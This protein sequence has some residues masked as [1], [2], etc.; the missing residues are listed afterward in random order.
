MSSI[1]QLP[2]PAHDADATMMALA[3][4]WALE[5]APAGRLPHTRAGRRDTVCFGGDTEGGAQAPPAARP[6]PSWGSSMRC[7]RSPGQLP[8]QAQGGEAGC[9]GTGDR[10]HQPGPMQGRASPRDRWPSP[11]PDGSLPFH[12]P[13][14]RSVPGCEPPSLP[15][16]LGPPAALMPPAPGPPKFQTLPGF[17]PP[18]AS[19]ACPLAFLNF[20]G[21]QRQ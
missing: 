10:C 16:E 19:P 3:Q 11:S 6:C 9:C 4:G 13:N 2:M 8:R 14:R 20:S 1:T 21:M 7:P 18:G 5:P 17:A 15:S 12:T